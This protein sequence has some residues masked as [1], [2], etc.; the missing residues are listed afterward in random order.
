MSDNAVEDFIAMNDPAW[1]D[2]IRTMHAAVLAGS[3]DL[4]TRIAYKLLMYTFGDHKRSW[5]CAVGSTKIGYG[6]RFLYGVMLD[7]PK[8]V[9]RSGSST[10]MTIDFATPDDVDAELVTAY[11]EQAAGKFDAFL[12]AQQH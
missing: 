7:D 4:S 5:V 2:A 12:A 10:L 11:V 6:V 9:L 1:A 8:S 3:P